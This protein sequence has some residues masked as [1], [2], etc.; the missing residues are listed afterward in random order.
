[1]NKVHIGCDTDIHGQYS[2]GFE[3]EGQDVVCASSCCVHVHERA[4]WLTC[5]LQA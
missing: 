2:W 1:M 4:D 5:L 3:F